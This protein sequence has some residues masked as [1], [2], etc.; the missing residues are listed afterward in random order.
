VFDLACWDGKWIEDLEVG[1]SGGAARG[2]SAVRGLEVFND[3][4]AGATGTG[5]VI[6]E[7]GIGL[8]SEVTVPCGNIMLDEKIPGTIH[9][10]VGDNR[11]LG[12]V[13]ESSLHWDLLVM[14]PTVTVDGAALPTGGDLAV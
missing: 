2:V 12:G 7:L 3:A 1:F 10:A 9:I 8:N 11:M 5:N 4:L 14:N 13:N 6:G